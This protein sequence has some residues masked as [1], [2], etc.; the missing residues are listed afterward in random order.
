[1]EGNKILQSLSAKKCV[2]PF[3]PPFGMNIPEKTMT[4]AGL[5]AIFFSF[6]SP[7]VSQKHEINIVS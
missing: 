5:D 3:I 6:Q 1:M 2:P 4:D 7:A